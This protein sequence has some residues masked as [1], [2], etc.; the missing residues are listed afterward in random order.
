MSPVQNNAY[1]AIFS[2]FFVIPMVL[3]FFAIFAI[4]VQTDRAEKWRIESARYMKLVSGLL[5][6]AFGLLLVLRIF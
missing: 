4:K 2:L 6:V 5:M 1:T 3:V